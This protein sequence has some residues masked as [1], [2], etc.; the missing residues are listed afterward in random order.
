MK[1]ESLVIA[2]FPYDGVFI[3]GPCTDCLSHYGIELAMLKIVILTARK[4]VS[5]VRLV[6]RG[7]HILFRES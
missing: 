3:L 7:D 2:G 4:G 6:T 5:K 1:A